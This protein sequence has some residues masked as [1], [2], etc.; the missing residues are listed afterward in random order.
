MLYFQKCQKTIRLDSLIIHTDPAV[1]ARKVI[2]KYD[3][4]HESHLADVEQIIFYLKN[5]QEIQ[6]RVG[7]YGDSAK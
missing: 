1:L 4:I 7:E 6:P 3:F 2:E 5:R